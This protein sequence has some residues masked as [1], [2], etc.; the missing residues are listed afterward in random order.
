MVFR[1]RGGRLD[2]FWA[3]GAP[4]AAAVVRVDVVDVVV[5]VG[6]P[7]EILTG[8]AATVWGPLA[9]VVV[10]VVVLVTTTM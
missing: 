9:V 7:V 3:R 1:W 4:G 8:P 5:V 10:V 2:F 6:E